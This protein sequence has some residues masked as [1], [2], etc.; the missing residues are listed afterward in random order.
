MQ[1][2]SCNL[3]SCTARDDEK[4]PGSVCEACY[5]ETKILLTEILPAQ[6]A[7]SYSCGHQESWGMLPQGRP[8]EKIDGKNY[9]LC[10]WP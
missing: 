6:Y 7:H 10:K 1:F 8:T 4:I 2:R 5:S 9:C 3:E